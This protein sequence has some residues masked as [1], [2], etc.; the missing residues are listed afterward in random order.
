[1]SKTRM[2]PVALFLIALA[3]T[4]CLL[5]AAGLSEPIPARASTTPTRQRLCP[6]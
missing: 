2:Y 1:M 4:T 3:G 6:P 5:V